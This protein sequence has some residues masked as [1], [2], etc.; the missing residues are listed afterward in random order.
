MNLWAR[1]KPREMNVH[2]HFAKRGYGS[3]FRTNKTPLGQGFKKL[4]KKYWISFNKMNG[5]MF[6][7]CIQ[8]KKWMHSKYMNAFIFWWAKS[9][10]LSYFCE[11]GFDQQLKMSRT[12]LICVRWSWFKTFWKAIALSTFQR[13]WNQLQRRHIS[14][15]VAICTW[16]LKRVCI[17]S[18]QN[19]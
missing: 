8:N 9:D 19:T 4:I 2:G 10:M 17:F 16:G 1:R 14:W 18:S 3:E 12:Q 6:F 5:P 13:V 11:I 7:E 15:V